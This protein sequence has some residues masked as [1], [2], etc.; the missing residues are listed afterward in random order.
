MMIPKQGESA[1][2]LNPTSTPQKFTQNILIN[3]KTAFGLV[4]KIETTKIFSLVTYT[5]VEHPKKLKV[6][7]LLFTT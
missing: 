5:E 4:S 3:S 6:L 2:M 1:Y 7:I